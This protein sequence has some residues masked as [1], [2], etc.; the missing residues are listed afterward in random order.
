MVDNYAQHLDELD[1]RL[2]NMGSGD[3]DELEIPQDEQQ[4]L[5]DEWAALN[6]V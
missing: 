5:E 1:A 3:E 2:E 6:A 4:E